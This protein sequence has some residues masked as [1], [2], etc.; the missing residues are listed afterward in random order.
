MSLAGSTWHPPRRL[1]RCCVLGKQSHSENHAHSQCR[2]ANLRTP[3]L[4]HESKRTLSWVKGGAHALCST[5]T[6]LR[7]CNACRQCRIWRTLSRRS[8]CART[9]L[10]LPLS[11]AHTAQGQGGGDLQSGILGRR[12]F[13][14]L[15]IMRPGC[16]LRLEGASLP[17]SF[18]CPVAILQSLDCLWLPFA[19]APSTAGYGDFKVCAGGRAAAWLYVATRRR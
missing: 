6:R 3:P 2:G 19:P 1:Y 11:L 15:A 10:G 16:H 18:A 5:W 17:P 7:A 12:F 9:R 4:P 13:E 8:V 14:T